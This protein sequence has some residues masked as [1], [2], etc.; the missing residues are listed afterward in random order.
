LKNIYTTNE[1]QRMLPLLA[2][3]LART[4]CEFDS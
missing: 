1:P 2:A 3:E 4:C